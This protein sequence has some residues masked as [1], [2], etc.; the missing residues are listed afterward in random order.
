M[1]MALVMTFLPLAKVTVPSSQADGVSC[2]TTPEVP[3][4][5]PLPTLLTAPSPTEVTAQINEVARPTSAK[6]ATF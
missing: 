2:N 6:R 1:V 4:L 3:D 5:T